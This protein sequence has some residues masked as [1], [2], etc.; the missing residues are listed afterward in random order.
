MAAVVT[1]EEWED[2]ATRSVRVYSFCRLYF[3]DSKGNIDNL[4]FTRRL[5]HPV[6]RYPLVE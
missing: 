6:G 2:K 3:F 1:Y 5:V 4:V